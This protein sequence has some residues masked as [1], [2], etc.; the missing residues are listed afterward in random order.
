M[1]NEEI[2]TTV[3][4]T[5]VTETETTVQTETTDGDVTDQ[6]V[7][8]KKKF[9]E[10]SREAQRLLD[11]IKERDRIQAEKDAEIERLRQLAEGNGATTPNESETIYPGFDLLTEEEQ[12]NLIAFKEN[13]KKNALEEVYKDPAIAFARQSFNEKKWNDAFES[14]ASKY[15]EIRE[16]KDDFKAKYFNANN[17]PDNISNILEDLSKVYLFDRAR[18]IGAKEALE[19][20][21]RIEIERSGGGDKTPTTV[22]RSLEEWNR[23]AQENPAKFAKMK[24]E[25]ERDMASGKLK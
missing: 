9:S 10:S 3:E 24:E 17:V 12:K 18:D 22:S 6:D 16:S 25:F 19:K 20:A 8:Y 5:P 14:I 13:I 1:S 21:G 15:P 11:E 4:E 7:D 2:Q 23:I